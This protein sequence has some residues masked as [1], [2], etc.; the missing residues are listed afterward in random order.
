MH[1]NIILGHLLRSVSFA[2]TTVSV[3]KLFKNLPVRRQCFSSTKKC[4]EELKKVQDLL[5]AYAI[6]KPELRLML[7]HNKVSNS[8]TQLKKRNKHYLY[9]TFKNKVLVHTGKAEHTPDIKVIKKKATKNANKNTTKK[10]DWWKK[11]NSNIDLYTKT[12]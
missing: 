10:K 5:M 9:T 11:K 2:G 4:K 1:E 6:I 7:V 3:M 8:S 12:N